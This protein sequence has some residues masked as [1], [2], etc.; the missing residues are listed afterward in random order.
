MRFDSLLSTGAHDHLRS[1]TTT[2]DDHDRDHDNIRIL[3]LH[4]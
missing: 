4:A 2:N 3:R 1:T